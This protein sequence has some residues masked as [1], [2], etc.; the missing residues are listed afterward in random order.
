[1]DVT[2]AMVGPRSPLALID[3]ALALLAAEVDLRED[4]GAPT[5]TVIIASGLEASGVAK[6]LGLYLVGALAG[7][8]QQDASLC[9]AML[10]IGPEGQREVEQA[11]HR[12]VGMN[13][14]FMTSSEISFRD[15]KRNAWIAEGVMH[16]LLMIRARSA[17]DMLDGPVHALADLHTIPTQQGL[18]ALAIYTD[19]SGPVVAIGESKASRDDGSGQLTEAATIFRD[20]DRMK[21]GPELRAKLGAL[22]R[23]INPDLAEKVS[24]ALWLEHRCYFPMVVHET[25]FDLKAKRVVYGRLLPSIDRRRVIGVRLQNFQKFFDDISDAMRDAVAEV[26]I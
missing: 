9:D 16:A 7:A 4:P 11:V 12:L 2:S 3:K 20:I 26:V 14:Q 13:N 21:Y 1:M 23:V 25:H 5:H 8:I 18:D 6:S 15:T 17:S 10:P 24:N 22:R 19:A